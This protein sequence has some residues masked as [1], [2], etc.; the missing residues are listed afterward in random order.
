M[1]PNATLQLLR[2]H[3]R[4]VLELVDKD[5]ASP[6]VTANI[7]LAAAKVAEHVTDLDTWITRG[8]ALPAEWSGASPGEEH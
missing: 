6:I 5:V 8:G 3:A 4:R 7:V 1:N 2:F